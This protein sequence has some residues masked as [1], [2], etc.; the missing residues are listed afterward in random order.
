MTEEVFIALGGNVG[1]VEKTFRQAIDEIA[2]F[3]DIVSAS[4]LYETEPWGMSYQPNFLNC[5]I[6]VKFDGKPY[7]LLMKLQE[8]ES[9]FGRVRGMVWGPRTID[10]DIILYGDRTVDE[11]DLQIPHKYLLLRDFFLVPLLETAP[12]T[13]NPGDGIKLEEYA[14]RIPE[15]IKTIVGKKDSKVWLEQIESLSKRL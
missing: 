14:K 6:C 11:P 4:S 7:E 10:L 13:K 15:Q 8:I 2:L 1:D 3:C 12:D 5:V 9:K